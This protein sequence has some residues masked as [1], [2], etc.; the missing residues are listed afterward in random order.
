M[1]VKKIL[2]I[3]N[4]DDVFTKLHFEFDA[5]KYELQR[6]TNPLLSVEILNNNYYAVVAD[7][8]M[9]EIFMVDMLN[10]I[11]F[12]HTNMPVVLLSSNI[13]ADDIL[14]TYE[15]GF[16]EILPKDYKKGE[17]KKLIECAVISS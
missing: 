12:V 16:L 10:N 11:G 4:D 13:T 15:F 7:L 6:L 8:S 14:L 5:N 1:N 17:I 9:K 2:V 3:T